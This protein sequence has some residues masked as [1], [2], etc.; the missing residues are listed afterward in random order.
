[1]GAWEHGSMGAGNGNGPNPTSPFIILWW[2]LGKDSNF[3]GTLRE[4]AIT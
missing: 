1:M 2:G 3:E 4:S